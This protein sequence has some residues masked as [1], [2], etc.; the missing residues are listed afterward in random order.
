MSISAQ[1]VDEV[2]DGRFEPDVKSRFSIDVA[3]VG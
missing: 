1:N 2:Y 3:S